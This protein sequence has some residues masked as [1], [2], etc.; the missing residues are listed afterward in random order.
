MAGCLHVDPLV[1]SMLHIPWVEGKTS[2]LCNIRCIGNRSYGQSVLKMYHSM[3]G[4]I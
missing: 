4:I 2:A 3:L 1:C